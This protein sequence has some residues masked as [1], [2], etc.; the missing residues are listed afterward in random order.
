MLRSIAELKAP[1]VAVLTEALSA[2]DADTGK[3]HTF[4]CII[5]LE[6]KVC[7]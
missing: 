5:P 6:I 2:V 4:Q 7:C 1:S 3:R